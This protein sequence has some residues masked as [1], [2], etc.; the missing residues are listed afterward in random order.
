MIVVVFHY[1][2]YILSI[3][4]QAAVSTEGG[5]CDGGCVALSVCPAGGR[6]AV[7]PLAQLQPGPHTPWTAGPGSVP[8][9]SQHS[10]LPVGMCGLQ[11]GDNRERE[12][13]KQQIVEVFLCVYIQKRN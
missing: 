1:I 9:F 6:I 2:W 5:S 4:V 7:V 8:A 13:F 12:R 3:R 11:G 10:G